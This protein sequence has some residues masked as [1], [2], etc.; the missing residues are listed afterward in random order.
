MK[1]KL[2]ILGLALIA[3]CLAVV[4]YDRIVPAAAVHAACAQSLQAANPVSSHQEERTAQPVVLVGAG[5]VSVL[6]GVLAV[7]PLLVGEPGSNGKK[8]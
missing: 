4:A 8:W 7:S 5:L 3:V 6:L 1:K 2:M